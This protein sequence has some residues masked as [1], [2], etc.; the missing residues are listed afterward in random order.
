MTR[1]RLLAFATAVALAVAL[2]GAV[3]AAPPMP[4]TVSISNVVQSVCTVTVNVDITNLVGGHDTLEFDLIN[5]GTGYPVATPP[6]SVT[7]GHGAMTA[8]GQVEMPTN[9][10]I[11]LLEVYLYRGPNQIAPT[12]NY[13][14]SPAW[15]CQ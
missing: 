6:G 7:L 2:P 8:T 12:A 15:S 14:F 13:F 11:S 9:T 10:S 5:E 4:S 1:L 3:A